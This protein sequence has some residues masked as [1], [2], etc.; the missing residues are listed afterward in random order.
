[1]AGCSVI[2]IIIP[3]YNAGKY[4]HRCVDSVLC[5]TYSNF[6]LI[7]IDDGSTDGSGDICGEYAEKDSRIKVFHKE[8]GGASSA[9][10]LGLSKAKGEYIVFVDADDAVDGQYL[11]HLLSGNADLV[12]GG[13]V[14]LPY[15]KK[16]F[17]D[18]M[19]AEKD[20]LTKALKKNFFTPPFFPPWAKLFKRAIIEDNKIR[21]NTKLRLTEDGLFVMQYLFHCNS[22]C[23]IEYTDYCYY[24]CPL[25]KYA[26]SLEEYKYGLEQLLESY[27]MLCEKFKFSHKDFSTIQI[28]MYTY[29][30]FNKLIQTDLSFNEYKLFKQTFMSFPHV[31]CVKVGKRILLLVISLLERKCYFSAYM[32]LKNICPI[33]KKIGYNVF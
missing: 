17:C 22:I 33:L 13:L 29:C 1:M 19:Y 16:Q 30:L 18:Y 25:N 2:S 5:Q 20:E 27:Q 28:R 24:I 7:L 32:V 12:I 15:G 6:E 14:E 3:V 10:N 21:F 4:L 31:S 26:L 11:E 8:N 9:R 23:F